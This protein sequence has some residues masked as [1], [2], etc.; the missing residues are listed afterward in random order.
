[1]RFPGFEGE[2]E[3][4]RL[5]EV[6]IVNPT[7]PEMPDCFYYI[8]L[9]SVSSG[10]LLKLK[11][12][13]KISAPSRAQRVVEK[14]DV[15]YQTVRPYQQ[16]NYIVNDSFNLPIVASTGYA[17]IR[18]KHNPQFLYSS[19]HTVRF[20]N[21]IMLRCT[22]SNYPAINSNNLKEISI[23]LP[24]QNEQDKIAHFMLLL[25][26]RI[27]KQRQLVEALKLYKR[28]ALFELF[29]Q[30]GETVPQYRFAGYT[31]PWEQR[32]LEEVAGVY[33]GVHQT[34]DYKTH[35]IMFLSVENI[36]TLKSEKYISE[37][38]FKR[39]YK[40][41]PEYGDVL[42][43]RIGDVGT[44]NVVETAEKIAFYVS[45]ALLKPREIDSYFLCNSILSPNFQKGL[46][47]RT[48]V[49]AI[50][51]KINKDEIGKVDMTVP[52]S[53]EEQRLIGNFFQRLNHLI[54]L[55]QRKLSEFESVKSG[56]LQQLFI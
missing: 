9:E 4:H 56:L 52:T 54:T 39:D 34:P 53:V 1:M 19:L 21:E 23:Y 6:A 22:G 36:A 3:K 55:H 48:L 24:I 17:Q 49:T 45:L 11:I 26:K 43:T 38:A 12:V 42:M 51:Q 25:N 13:E 27:E 16:N 35:G 29:P 14:G 28:G 32:K 33:D 15:L 37:E 31:E 50:P 7:T 41:F 2:W 47:D 18:T 46:K 40:V 8:D 10:L 20:L 30:K 44:P 5:D